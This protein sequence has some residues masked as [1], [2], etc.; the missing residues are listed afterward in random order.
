MLGEFTEC[1]LSC[2]EI[3]TDYL[4]SYRGL[5]LR[6]YIHCSVNHNAGEYVRGNIHTQTIEAFWS[7][8]KRGISGTHIHVSQKHLPKYL[9][10]FEY[11]WNMRDQGHLMID[12]LMMAFW[13]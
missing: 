9:G 13:R 8:V 5:A 1:L 2:F 3:H 11:R 12:R 7:A 6:G 4:M 10:E